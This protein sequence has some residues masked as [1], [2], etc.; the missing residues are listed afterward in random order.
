LYQNRFCFFALISSTYWKSG[1]YYPNF[2]EFTRK[3]RFILAIELYLREINLK[4]NISI[5]AQKKVLFIDRDGTIIVEP[6]TD[7]QV[8]SLEKL[9][10]VPQVISRL[11]KIA[12]EL[13]YEL[14]MVT[15]QDG[16]GT[17]SFPEETFHPAHNKMLKVLEG[18]GIHFTKI[19]IDR[20]FPHENKP[21]RKPNTGMLTEYMNGN[22]DLENSFVIGDRATDVQLAQNLGSKSI[23]YASQEKAKSLGANATFTTESWGE[24]YQFLVSQQGRKAKIYRKT[25]ETDIEIIL[26]LDGK[27]KCTLDT[28]IGFFDH[29]LEQLAR[30]SG[31]DL[32]VKV[33]GDLHIDEHHTIEDTA[34][35]IGQAFKQALG[36]KRGIQRYGFFILPMDDVLAQVALDF[37]GRPW[38]VM[39]AKFTRERV[40]GMPTEMFEHF[41][42]SF[43]DTALCN[44][45][46]KVEGN[47]AHHQIEAIFK[48]FARAIRMAIHKET[49]NQEIPSSKGV[50]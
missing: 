16:L 44:L 6:P 1:T 2:K 4:K 13:D 14:V 23:L 38:L 37:S 25:K 46:I 35:A 17:S 40:G 48:A 28:G 47:N 3:I 34:L 27:G 45:N 43:S 29:M 41:F 22:Y 7:F 10:F 32:S 19:H 33:K 9:E 11:Q 20:S 50:L 12:L 42:K 8:D 18:E 24:I 31:C 49:G 30:H 26:D 5:M 15:N 21:T 39:N 36:E